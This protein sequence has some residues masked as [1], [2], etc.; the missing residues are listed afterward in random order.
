M[1]KEVTVACFEMQSQNLRTELQTTT[2]WFRAAGLWAKNWRQ[3]LSNTKQGCVEVMLHKV[4]RENMYVSN[5][6]LQTMPM[7]LI[8]CTQILQADIC[9]MSSHQSHVN[10]NCLRN[11]SIQG[12]SLKEWRRLYFYNLQ[13]LHFGCY[14]LSPFIWLNPYPTNVENRVSS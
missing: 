6:I 11:T 8:C 12:I 9:G 7:V 10:L 1:W 4:R 2:K 14:D 5:A 3:I 13:Y